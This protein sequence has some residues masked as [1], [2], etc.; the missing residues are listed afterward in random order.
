MKRHE[1]SSSNHTLKREDREWKRKRHHKL[2]NLRQPF[3]SNPSS[4][5]LIPSLSIPNESL[6][7]SHGPPLAHAFSLSILFLIQTLYQIKYNLMSAHFGSW[8]HWREPL[9]STPHV[10][11]H[12]REFLLIPHHTYVHLLPLNVIES[13]LNLFLLPTLLSHNLRET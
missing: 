7:V 12:W 8:Q 3:L 10:P 9:V 2:T 11:R 4:F 1:L 13:L 5:L 6:S